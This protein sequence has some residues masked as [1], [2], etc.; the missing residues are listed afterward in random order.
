MHFF[1]ELGRVRNV[2]AGPDGRLWILTNNTDGR[3]RPGEGDDRL[4]TVDPRVLVQG[5]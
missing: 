4:L 3:G 2:R 1:G 5:R